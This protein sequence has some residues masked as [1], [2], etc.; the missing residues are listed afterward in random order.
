MNSP[1]PKDFIDIH[2]HYITP[3]EGVFAVENFMV[4][5]E[6]HYD[7]LSGKAFTAG[8]HP[9]YLNEK[10]HDSLIESVRKISHDSNLIA[11]GEAGYD[12]LRGPSMEL[13]RTTFEEQAKIACQ[14]QKP[15]VIHCVKAWDELLVS[16]KH[17]KPEKPWLIHGFRGK[18][19][20]ASQLISRGMYISFWFDFILRPESSDLVR[21]LPRERIFLE[22]DGADV[23]ISMIY[24]KVSD[25]L[26]VS[27]G[28]LKNIICKNY[29]VLFGR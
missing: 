1:H 24:K 13:Q 18:K 29:K 16:H 6:F 17:L 22:T 4:H 2:T 25:D 11:I 26:S 3:V 9:W 8:I 21:F 20:L 12:K 28:T 5:E 27:L 7:K 15:L 23:N 14:I 19:E 10:N